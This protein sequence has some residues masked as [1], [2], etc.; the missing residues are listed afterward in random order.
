MFII[1]KKTISMTVFLFLSASVFGRDW[2]DQSDYYD[3]GSGSDDGSGF[4]I[5]VMV[6]IAIIYFLSKD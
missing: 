3:Y 5:F 1:L 2:Y 6:V 4:G